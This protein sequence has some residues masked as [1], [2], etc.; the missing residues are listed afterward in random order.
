V[1]P[2]NSI[3][4]VGR[5]ERL[6]CREMGQMEQARVYLTQAWESFEEMKSPDAHKVREWLSKTG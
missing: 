4:K 5:R 6:G 2:A 3:D 1:P